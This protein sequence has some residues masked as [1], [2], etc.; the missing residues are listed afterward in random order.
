MESIRQHDP[1]DI[2]AERAQVYTRATV[3]LLLMLVFYALAL[4]V[5]AALGV[6][7]VALLK[8]GGAVG[9]FVGASLGVGA[10]VVAW[11]MLPRGERFVPP[12]PE[13]DPDTHEALFR[14]VRQLAE[15]TKQKMPDRIYL[16]PDVNAFVGDFGGVLGIGSTR[17]LGI[18]LPLMCGLDM[19]ELRSVLGHEFGHFCGGDTRLGPW[20]YRGRRA[21][22]SAAI[23]LTTVARLLGPAGIVFR[24]LSVPFTA[25]ATAFLRFTQDLSRRQELAADEVGAKLA[26]T[27][28]SISA[29][30]AVRVCSAAF[31]VYFKSELAPLIALGRLAPVAEGFRRFLRTDAA[32][33]LIAQVQAEPHRK[34]DALDSHPSLPERI[35]ALQAIAGPRPGR[36]DRPASELLDELPGYELELVRPMLEDPNA[37]LESVTW[38]E[39]GRVLSEQWLRTGAELA[40]AYLPRQFDELPVDPK[41]HRALLGRHLAKDVSDV[42]DDDV[43]G[44]ARWA[45]MNMVFA[46]LTM[47]GMKCDSLP[48]EPVRFSDGRAHFEAAEMVD[49]LLRGAMGREDWRTFCRESGLSKIDVEVLAAHSPKYEAE[50]ELAEA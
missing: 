42:S 19:Q 30:N 20:I 47:T 49:R 21:M 46:G 24:A 36:D 22:I 17:V 16:L 5:V 11:S 4:F 13:L 2:S 12:G 6:A 18:G 39:V 41:E 23:N 48:G 32:K 10:A 31:E 40:V 50:R 25:Y 15:D 3:S 33:R 37:E 1:M 45:L 38:K 8:L 29:L 34:A 14:E 9:F 27:P 28:S 44:W 7:A 35:Y 26:G 43:R